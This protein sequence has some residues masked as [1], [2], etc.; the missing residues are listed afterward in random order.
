MGKRQED[1]ESA[2]KNVD[3]HKNRLDAVP[4]KKRQNGLCQ[5]IHSF[6]RTHACITCSVNATEEKS[7]ARSFP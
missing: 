3:E 6:S 1:S 5:V 2:K 7:A 4:K